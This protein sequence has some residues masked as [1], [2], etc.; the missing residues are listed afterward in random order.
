M[1]GSVVVVELE[2]LFLSFQA[3]G[4]CDGITPIA[5]PSSVWSVLRL[6]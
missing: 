6:A 2:R 3:R 5:S 1:K 4:Q